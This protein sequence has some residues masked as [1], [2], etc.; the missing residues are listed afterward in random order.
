[1]QGSGATMLTTNY[2]IMLATM[3]EAIPVTSPDILAVCSELAGEA[4]TDTWIS[5]LIDAPSLGA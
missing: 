3:M 4:K 1:M 2:A 5:Q